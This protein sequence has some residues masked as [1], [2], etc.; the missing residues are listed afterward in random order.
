[1]EIKSVEDTVKDSVNVLIYGVSSAGK[2]SLLS[3]LK[4]KTLIVSLEGGLLVL[5][6]SKMDVV[7]IETIDE[8]AEVYKKIKTGEWKYDNVAID[9]LSEVADKIVAELDADEYYQ[10]PSNAFVLWKDYSKRLIKIVKL[11][12][13]AKINVIFTALED[14]TEDNGSLTKNASIQ[15]KKA[16]AKLISL[17]DEFYRLHIDKEGDRWLGTAS[18]NFYLAKSRAGLFED[19]IKVKEGS[20][21][22]GEML[23]AIKTNTVIKTTK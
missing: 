22:L 18:S 4:G 7:E 10:N 12:R 5:R 14:T 9:S 3:G 1:M 13:D 21:I 15:G 16:Q 11:F 23:E 8:L 17:F 20:P 6:G 2:T 19:E